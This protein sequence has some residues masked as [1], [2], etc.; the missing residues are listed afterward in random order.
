MKAGGLNR[1]R[2]MVIP[3]FTFYPWTGLIV[4]MLLFAVVAQKHIVKGMTF[5]AVKG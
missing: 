3:M 2:F 4:S 1:A 5:G